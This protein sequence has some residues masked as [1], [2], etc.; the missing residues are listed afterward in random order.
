MARCTG[1]LEYFLLFSD[2]DVEVGDFFGYIIQGF[3]IAIG[4]FCGQWFSARH[5]EKRLNHFENVMQKITGVKDD[6]RKTESADD[7][8]VRQL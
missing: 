5:V 3:A 4:T 8:K 6:G 7:G 1:Q 2:G